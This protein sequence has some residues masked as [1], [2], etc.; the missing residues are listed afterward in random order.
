ML[1]SHEQKA[2]VKDKFVCETGRWIS[3]IRS[4]VLSI[5]VFVSVIFLILMFLLVTMDTEKPFDLLNH[6]FLCA[7]LKKIGF[8]TNVIN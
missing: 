4:Y 3:D 1:I 7:V 5:D 6:Y 8:A 2:S